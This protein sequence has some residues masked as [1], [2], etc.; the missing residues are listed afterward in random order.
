MAPLY[1]YLCKEC[2]LVEEIQHKMAE[3]PEVKCRCGSDMAKTITG[4][5]FQLIGGGWFADGYAARAPVAKKPP[6]VG[7]K[8]GTK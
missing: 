2:G 3:A 1:D 5:S 4:T 7:G 6:R 8:H